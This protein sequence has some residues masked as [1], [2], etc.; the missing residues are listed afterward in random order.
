MN[1]EHKTLP[2][3][4]LAGVIENLGEPMPCSLVFVLETAQG[5]TINL[6]YELLMRTLRFAEQAGV[7]PELSV[8]WWAQTAV[9]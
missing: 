7:M 5:Q 3:A 2:I 1:E 8:H 6:N 4:R 9:P